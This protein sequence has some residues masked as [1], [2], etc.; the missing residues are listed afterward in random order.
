MPWLH[1]A[2]IM[3]MNQMSIKT[4][5]ELIQL[6]TFAERLKYVCIGGVVGAET[7]GGRRLLNQD[8]YR[9]AEWRR[10]RDMVIVRDLG[11][12]LAHPDVPIVG[13]IIVHHLNPINPSDLVNL[14]KLLDPELMVSTSLET[15]NAI[16]YGDA[17]ERVVGYVPRSQN[18][19]CPWR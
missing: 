18:D 12:D 15:H 4:Y 13:T 9:S 2:G 6:P 5:S 10:A 8:F 16:H 1:F 17:T 3:G 19:T 11:C 14:R 7:F